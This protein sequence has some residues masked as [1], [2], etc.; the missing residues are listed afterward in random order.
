MDYFFSQL[1]ESVPQARTLEQL[2]RPLLA[3][4]GA[5]SGPN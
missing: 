2:T 4:L 3:M 5:A 1:S